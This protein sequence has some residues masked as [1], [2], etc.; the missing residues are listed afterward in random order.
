MHSGSL[1]P[2]PPAA[3]GAAA[4]KILAEVVVAERTVTARLASRLDT[5]PL[6]RVEPSQERQDAR[7]DHSQKNTPGHVSAIAMQRYKL[8]PAIVEMDHTDLVSVHQ[9]AWEPNARRV[10]DTPSRVARLEGA[11]YREARIPIHDSADQPVR[12]TR[13][14]E[15]QEHKT[16]V[17][18]RHDSPSP[19]PANNPHQLPTTN[20][21]QPPPAPNSTALPGETRS[22]FPGTR[23]A[24]RCRSGGLVRCSRRS[25]PPGE[26]RP[27]PT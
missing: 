26:V 10:P 19:P 24:A 13:D 1:G 23:Q 5:P 14:G 2:A 9:I 8:G 4:V 17:P 20:H 6:R 21:H 27:G 18:P 22:A 7:R 15:D 11:S 16:N 25:R 3:F 12:G